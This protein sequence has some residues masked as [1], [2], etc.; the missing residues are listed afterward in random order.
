MD[1]ATGAF[2][3]P[4][5]MTRRP[6]SPLLVFAVAAAG[7]A[8]FSSMD[9]VMKLLVR[10]IGTYDAL[11]WR[12][13]AGVALTGLIHLPGRP[14]WP[15]RASMR[16]HVIRG[17]VSAVMALTFFWGLARVPMAQAIALSFIAPLLALFGAAFLLK[18]R[19]TRG[20]VT[21]SLVAFAGVAVIMLGQAS[22]APSPDRFRGTIAILISALCYAYNIV[23]M[24]QQALVAG[25]GEVAFWQSVIVAAVLAVAAPFLAHVPDARHVPWIVLA[26]VLATVSLM[27]LA[28]AYARGQA[29]Y[30]APTEYTGFVWASLWGWAVFREPIALYTLAGA[31]MIVAGCLIAVRRRGVETV[32]AAF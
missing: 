30:L 31:A 18:E 20:A 8:V 6:P 5:A 25:P 26:A 19:I 10:A 22:A 15:S 11:W 13:L 14:R 28:W 27:L 32:E 4:P 7:I 16:V 12:T 24:R 9:A 23:L 2:G 17:L 1:D 29:S 3:Y 21:A